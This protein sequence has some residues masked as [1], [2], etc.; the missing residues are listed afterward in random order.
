MPIKAIAACLKEVSLEIKDIDLI[1]IPGSTYPEQELRT[2]SWIIHHFGFSPRVEVLNHQLAHIYSI[3][4]LNPLNGSSL[5]SSDAY[6]DRL[7]GVIS[8]FDGV[9]ETPIIKRIRS[10]LFTWKNLWS[11]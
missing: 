5:L 4:A 11:S 1:I 10:K 9:V 7:C 3:Y 8:K 6:G 2:K